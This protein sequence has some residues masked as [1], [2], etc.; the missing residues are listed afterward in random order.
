MLRILMAGLVAA[1]A[2]IGSAVAQNQ[3]DVMAKIMALG[4][5]HAPADRRASLRNSSAE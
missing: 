5:I 4:W 2:A 3:S 1:F